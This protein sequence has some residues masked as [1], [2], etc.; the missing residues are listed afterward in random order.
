MI[1]WADIRQK[2]DIRSSKVVPMGHNLTKQRVC[3]ICYY[4]VQLS[5]RLG[6]AKFKY[7]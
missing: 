2:Y 6:T 1:D 5:M 7:K 3:N 4:M